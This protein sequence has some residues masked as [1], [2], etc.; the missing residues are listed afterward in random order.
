MKN[1]ITITNE[2]FEILIP[3]S[4]KEYGEEVLNY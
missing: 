3:L 2:Y 4:L 1:Y